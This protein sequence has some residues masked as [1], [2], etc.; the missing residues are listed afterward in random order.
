M[1]GASRPPQFGV[2]DVLRGG[3]HT[4]FLNGELDLSA[5][6]YL[7]AVILRLLVEGIEGLSLNLSKLSFIDATGLRALLAVRQLCEQR[8]YAFVLTRPTGQVRRLIE[9]TDAAYDLP[10]QSAA[11]SSLHAGGQICAVTALS[12]S[13]R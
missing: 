3:R 4:L 1:T 10:V 7:E 6:D 2:Q 5:A 8:G 9:L 12:A 11:E 13:R